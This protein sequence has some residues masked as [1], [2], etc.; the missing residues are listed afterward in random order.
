MKPQTISTVVLAIL[1][2][3]FMF[4]QSD[5]LTPNSSLMT[6]SNGSQSLQFF[7]VGQVTLAFKHH[8]SNQS[9]FRL[10]ADISGLFE[11]QKEDYGRL[12]FST[13]S[14]ELT[15]NNQSVKLGVEYLYYFESA[16]KVKIFV[17]GGPS[18]AFTRSRYSRTNTMRTSSTTQVESNEQTENFWDVGIRGS[19]GVECHLYEFLSLIGQYQLFATY[20]PHKSEGSYSSSGNSSTQYY[21]LIKIWRIQL[22]SIQLG[23]SI[24][25]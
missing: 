20:G 18:V 8:V 6:L 1:W 12:D 7:L 14:R 9:A 11:K 17:G 4:A 19:A 15:I 16:N 3:Q 13:Q 23:V 25:L 22:M 21:E 10:S 24:Y 5:S 2:H